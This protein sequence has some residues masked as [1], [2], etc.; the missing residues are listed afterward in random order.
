MSG[1]VFKG[2]V[3]EYLEIEHRDGVTDIK[4]TRNQSAADIASA[5]GDKNISR[6]RHLSSILLL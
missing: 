2:I 6:C 3:T 5:P 4:E 1:D